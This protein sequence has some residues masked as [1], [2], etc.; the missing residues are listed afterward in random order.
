MRHMLRAA[1]QSGRLVLRFTGIR[2]SAVRVVTRCDD[3]V[4]LVRHTYSRPTVWL[5]PGGGLK[6]REAPSLAAARELREEVGIKATVEYLGNVQTV[7]DG[8]RASTTG[9]LA[10]VDG[11]RLTV[12]PVEIEEARWFPLDSLPQE[13]SP[14]SVLLIDEA[15]GAV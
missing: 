13:M 14:A 11:R 3:E 10:W 15:Q 12:D 8:V 2:F 1:Y 9:F 5:L 4:L 6:P 7:E